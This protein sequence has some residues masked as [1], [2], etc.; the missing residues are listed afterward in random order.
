MQKEKKEM[1]CQGKLYGLSFDISYYK[2]SEKK[3]INPNLFSEDA[4]K[5]VNEIDKIL[6]KIVKNEKKE[7]KIP[8]FTQV[9]KFYHD[10]LNFQEKINAQ[11]EDKQKD[12]YIKQLPY[13]NM[14]LARVR[15]AY[16]R[17]KVNWRFLDFIQQNIAK[18]SD[19][20][21]KEFNIFCSLF[22]SVIAYSKGILK[23]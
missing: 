12:E 18:L 7:Q 16:D 13:I 4:Q 5:I 6:Y 9:R 21:P 10:V 15:Y 11:P 3:I 1:D 23:K 8:S 14:L 20:D 17:D 22:E 19:D 2:D